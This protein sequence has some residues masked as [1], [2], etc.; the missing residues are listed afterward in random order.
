MAT[1][2]PAYLA[3]LIE[4]E[5][6]TICHFVPSMLRAFL[7]EPGLQPRCRSLRDVFCSGEALSEDLPERFFAQMSAGLH[8]LYGPT[9]A[10]IDV[11]FWDCKRG[12]S[13]RIPIGRPVAN[14]KLY[15]LDQRLQPVPVGV[16]GELYIG[17]VQLARGYHN[18]PELTAERFL[19]NPFAPGERL[20][21]TGD[22]VRWRP[23]G[24]LEFLGRLDQQ[25]KL[26]GFRIEL[27]EVEAVLGQ[28]PQ[29]R[30]AV[31]LL[32]EDHPDDKHLVAY[33][34]SR[35]EEAP[36]P[37]QLRDFLRDKLPEYMVPSAFV[38]LPRLPLT[39]NGKVDRR[40]LPPP[41]RN[42]PELDQTYVAP[43]TP[44]EE[45]LAALWAEALGV[46]R[47]GIHD[48][49]FARGGHSLLATRV[50]SRVQQA[51]GV[52]LPLR[53]LF[54]TPTIAGLALAIVERLLVQ[55]EPTG[56]KGGIA[57]DAGGGQR[58]AFSLRPETRNTT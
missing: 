22:R 49:F 11:T 18:R 10:A 24:N 28:H 35:E 6:I 50:L 27:G 42:R 5:Q 13:G 26:R 17:G 1:A 45:L 9:E 36:E 25:V 48:N 15:V 31:V 20:Y 21:R 8:N 43:R 14:T 41:D 29:V 30:Q 12:S 32:R 56:K 38:V 40:A 34:V 19:P 54:E 4:T 44:V 57:S 53:A 2:S 52:E 46:E 33:V 23:D 58:K 51:C 37:G 39:T 3:S 55:S 47:V 7:E 16:S